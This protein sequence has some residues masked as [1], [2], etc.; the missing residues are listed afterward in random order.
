MWLF[1]VRCLLNT[2]QAETNLR[3]SERTVLGVGWLTFWTG[4]KQTETGWIP[5][6]QTFNCTRLS[7]KVAHVH[8]K[9][10]G[11]GNTQVTADWVLVDQLL[12]RGIRRYSQPRHDTGG[13]G[14]RWDDVYRPSCTNMPN[15]GNIN[16]VT[17]REPIKFRTVENHALYTRVSTN[18]ENRFLCLWECES[19]NAA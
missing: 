3:L 15:R 19:F 11:R 7:A 6:N 13:G 8:G 12:T 18:F 9:C 4:N 10:G 5:L 2:Q 17:A 1:L 16:D 14:V